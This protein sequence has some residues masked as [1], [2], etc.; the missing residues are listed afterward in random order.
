MRTIDG[1]TTTPQLTQ[2]THQLKTMNN[3]QETLTAKT[4]QA[5]KLW[6]TYVTPERLTTAV[7]W[8]NITTKVAICFVAILTLLT[9]IVVGYTVYGL[10]VAITTTYHTYKNLEQVNS[11]NP[12]SLSGTSLGTLYD[13]VTSIAAYEAKGAVDNINLHIDPQ[14]IGKAVSVEVLY[15]WSKVVEALDK[16][17]MV[18]TNIQDYSETA[19]AVDESEAQDPEEMENT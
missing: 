6:K 16:G 9:L 12:I 17:A 14:A 2:L 11:S 3:I 19:V 8:V 4:S 15:L 13:L 7:K 1:E 18:E 10:L 5:K